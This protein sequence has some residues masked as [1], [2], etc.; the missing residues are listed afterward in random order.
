M[1]AE[2]W[3]L[4]ARALSAKDP[5]QEI[6]DATD[7][8]VAQ[9]KTETLAFVQTLQERGIANAVFDPLLTRGFDYYTGMVFEI[10]DTNPAN[11]R[12]L[13]GGGRYDE[14]VALFGG[15]PIPAVG[16]AFGDVTFADFLELHGYLPKKAG[17]PELFIGTTLASVRSAEKF[18]EELRMS[19]VRVFVNLR[20]KSL[21]DQ[22][23]DAE[24]R[25]IRYFLGYGEDEARAGTL[26][27]KDLPN[28]EN[29]SLRGSAEVADWI[30]KNR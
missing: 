16:F 7:P 20:D 29:T 28:Y 6:E 27:L 2:K 1:P 13:F 12:A 14:L 21:G 17:A 22:A 10:F 23:K 9:A 18:A 3:T 4:A 26:T 25:G 15:D 19:G 5:L 24:K 8:V 11:P 30:R